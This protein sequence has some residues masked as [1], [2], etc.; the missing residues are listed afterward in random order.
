[1]RQPCSG[2]PSLRVGRGACVRTVEQEDTS[3]SPM[4]TLTIGDSIM[5]SMARWAKQDDCPIISAA[6]VCA[7]G[8]SSCRSRIQRD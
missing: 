7:R 8:L 6:L 3:T 2:N 4:A 5:L 1:M